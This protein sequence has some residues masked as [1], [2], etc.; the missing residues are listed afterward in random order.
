MKSL[1]IVIAILLAAPF[2]V[3]AAQGA[4][5]TGEA[6]M[7]DTGGNLEKATFAGGCFWCVEAAFD[8]VDGVV[9]AVSGYAGGPEKDPTYEQVSSG[10]TGHYESVQVTFDPKVISYE[11]L[12]D[13]FW[14]Q[15]NPT[16]GGG[17]FADRGK[18][19]R[20]AIF[21]H[22]EAQREKAEASKKAL[23]ESGK[24]SDPIKVE[25]LPF[26]SFYPAEEYHQDYHLKNP[27]RY[28]S[29]K[30]LSGRAPYIKETW[31]AEKK[32]AKT[33]KKPDDAEL[34]KKLT[35]LQYKVAREDGTEPP[36][37][38]EYWDNKRPGI[39]VDVVS[40][41][42]LF[43][44]LDKYDS[45]TGWPSFTKPLAPDNIVERKDISLFMVRTDVRS[46]HGDS[47][48]GHVFDDGPEPTGLR[49]CMN[50]ASLRF[51]PAED[52]DKEGYGE[53]AKLF[54]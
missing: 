38:N 51:I 4:N 23:E 46:K 17:Q 34:K 41:E 20:P 40:G 22:D 43:S 5:A 44:S 12:L 13:I 47:H 52:L 42:P 14:R 37:N 31:G 26:S 45:G 50:S 21:V 9:S 27:G 33:Y 18:Q 48:L 19:Y 15:I 36:F 49:Y 7:G 11:K 39:Y 53:F 6:V 2:A 1:F 8:G 16:D 10:A 25:I 32:D 28:N 35:P 30:T 3:L 54:K 24:F 29:Y